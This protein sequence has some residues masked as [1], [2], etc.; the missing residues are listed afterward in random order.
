MREDGR[1]SLGAASLRVLAFLILTALA[2]MIVVAQ[3]RGSGA[4]LAEFSA[5]R[6]DEAAPVVGAVM[7]ADWIAGGLPAPAAFFSEQALRLPAPGL[8]AGPPL[9]A[10]ALGLWIT[11]LGP[12][13]PALLLLPA[14]LAALLVV[15]AGWATAHAAGPLPG[16]AT[17]AVLMAAVPLREAAIMAG[18][19]LPLALLSLLA[20]LAFA[21]A[22][23]QS[24]ASSMV[25]FSLAAAAA[26]LTAPDGAALLAVPLLGPLLGG[27][28]GLFA[29]RAFWLPLALI[30]L[31]AGPW[32]LAHPTPLGL[33]A[34]PTLASVAANLGAC[35]AA[36]RAGLGG[37]FVVLAAIGALAAVA[38][39][40]RGDDAA[41]PMAAVAALGLACLG[42]FALAAAP[43]DPGR[44]LVLVAPVVILSAYGA[45]SL[46][47]LVSSSWDTVFG[48][49]VAVVLLVAA[50]PALL[51][52]VRKS[53]VGMDEVA[54]AVV[55][56][57][58][59]RPVVLVAADPKGEGALIAAIA[60][61]DRAA[62]TIVVPL[63]RRRPDAD[64]A[65][66]LAE[67]DALGAAFLALDASTGARA[68]P[69]VQA[70]EAAV[71]AHPDRFRLVGAFPRAD[72]TG[73][74]RLYAVA[75]AGPA[76][77]AAELRRRLR[78]PAGG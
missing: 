46:L 77:D 15:S 39:A 17:G 57:K 25:L 11:G 48:L 49:A 74:A 72:G 30:A 66:V 9:P 54:Q 32:Y 35:A 41:R 50:M 67:I 12:L 76:P 21:G 68:L 29:R 14:F 56:G 6:A 8:G 16:V 60:Q 27:R 22:L 24:R 37:V 71:A 23:A 18:A 3:Q 52:P 40:W 73:Q 70:A 7:V 38:Q 75:G 36:L 53:V 2:A 59:E 58:R 61:H 4:Y 13:T 28:P 78:A 20:A 42:L 47:R 65:A 19:D 45:I 64:P 44:T 55:A 26:L 62:A 33:A 69:A 31:L 63:A 43:P 10:L 5:T 1:P 51:E 34:A